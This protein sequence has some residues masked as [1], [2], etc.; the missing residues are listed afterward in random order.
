MQLSE[1][2]LKKEFEYL[3]TC[4]IAE[5]KLK[6]DKQHLITLRELN[7]LIKRNFTLF[8]NDQKADIRKINH[9][10]YSLIFAN[11]LGV[12]ILTSFCKSICKYFKFLSK[13]FFLRNIILTAYFSITVVNNTL[14]IN[15][16]IRKK[17]IYYPNKI[18]NKILNK[19]NEKLKVPY[20]KNMHTYKP[21]EN[22]D[23][24]NFL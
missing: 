20:D 13:R 6:L 16:H 21:E 11:I 7:A 12:T 15:D 23:I 3:K 14:L 2:E 19:D 10:Y 4:K 8:T 1:E 5:A 9:L 24:F 18:K 17:L 22:Q